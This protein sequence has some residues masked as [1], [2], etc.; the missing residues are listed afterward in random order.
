MTAL[1]SRWPHITYHC[2]A[3]DTDY[4]GSQHEDGRVPA[5]LAESN[6]ISSEIARDIPSVGGRHTVMLDIDVPAVL[7]PSSTPGHSH[8]YIDAAMEWP[9]LE[10][11]LK[12]LANAGVIEPG[13]AGASISRG[14]TFLR[15]PWVRKPAPATTDL[16]T[17]GPF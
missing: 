9:V 11:L 12:A 8:L 17:E 3:L 4:D 10:A 16:S 5:D 14:A 7:V 2:D 6:T 1:Y 15:L 13:Y